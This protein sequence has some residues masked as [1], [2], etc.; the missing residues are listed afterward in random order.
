M[1]FI[2]KAMAVITVTSGLIAGGSGIA[3]AASVEPSVQAVSAMTSPTATIADT[4][5]D[6]GSLE[7]V[8]GSVMLPFV[9]P[10]FWVACEAVADTDN[11]S[12]QATGLDE[13]CASFGSS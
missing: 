4:G 9:Y 12:L 13:L 1:G 7:H 10:F 6:T 8:V 2:R 5:A 3:Q 11:L